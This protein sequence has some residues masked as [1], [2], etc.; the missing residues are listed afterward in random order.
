MSW[1]TGWG[2][3][4]YVLSSGSWAPYASNPFYYGAGGG[5]S[6]QF[7]RPSYQAGVVPAST[8]SMRAVPD[9]AMD[10]DPTTGFRMGETQEFPNGTVAF[11]FF[12]EGGTSLASPLMAGMEALAQQ[13]NGSRIGF[14]N[15]TIYALAKG[16]AKAFTDVTP[17][18]TGDANVRADFVN[19]VDASNGVVYSLRTFDQDSSLVVTKGWDDVTGIGSPNSNYVAIGG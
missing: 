4:K 18:H 11:G 5:F 19:G 2:T 13:V 8:G 10:A 9:V 14:A 12:R 3:D 7:N 6:A 16:G 1:E 17:V 15:P